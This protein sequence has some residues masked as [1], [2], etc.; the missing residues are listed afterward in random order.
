MYKD[1]NLPAI[2]NCGSMR[3][4]VVEMDLWINSG[5][6]KSIIHKVRYRLCIESVCIRIWDDII[7]SSDTSLMTAKLV[8]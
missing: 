4:S 3:N 1:L 2:M 7:D 5:G 6:A 8:G